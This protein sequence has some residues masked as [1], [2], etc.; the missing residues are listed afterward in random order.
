MLCGSCLVVLSLG[1]DT[2]LPQL[3]V[4]LRHKDF[5]TGLDGAEIVVV[6]LLPL[7][8]FCTDECSAAE[9]QVGTLFVQVEWHD[10]IFLL[11]ADGGLDGRVGRVA[12]QAQNAHRLLALCFH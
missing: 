7:G 10:E 11:T 6:H 12:E 1:K 4:K 5:Y 8:R 3:L 2:K 9:A